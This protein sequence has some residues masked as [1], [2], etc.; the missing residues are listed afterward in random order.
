M[1]DVIYITN[2]LRK[3]IFENDEP[4][5]INKGEFTAFGSFK[6]KD[7]GQFITSCDYIVQNEPRMTSFIVL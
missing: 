1:K 7:G 6:S 4:D 2:A 3:F 5:E